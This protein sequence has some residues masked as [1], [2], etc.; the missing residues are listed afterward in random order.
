[1]SVPP[2]L[3]SIPLEWRSS[4][5]C[6]YRGIRSLRRSRGSRGTRRILRLRHAR[7][8]GHEDGDTAGPW[9]SLYKRL[10]ILS[11]GWLIFVQARLCPGERGIVRYFRLA[12]HVVKRFSRLEY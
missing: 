11:A 4:T 7:L 6:P 2:W 5:R 10:D 8:F 3:I 9:G 1:M 12:G